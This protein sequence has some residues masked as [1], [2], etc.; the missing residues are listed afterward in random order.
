MREGEGRERISRLFVKNICLTVP[1][2]FVKEPSIVSLIAGIEKF[3]LKGVISRSS[4]EVFL[5]R[6]TEKLRR[7]TPSY[8]MFQ[9][10]SAGIKVYG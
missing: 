7:G 3:M 10:V 8:A 9:K 5:P 4:V 1:K 6:S 2:N